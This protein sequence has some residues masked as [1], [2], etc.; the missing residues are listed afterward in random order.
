[1]NRL[2]STGT[3][4]RAQMSDASRAKVTVKAKGRK[5]WLTRPPTRPRGRKTA[6]VVRVELVM[7]LATSRVP[8]MHA[9]RIGSP[10]PRCR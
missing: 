9:W 6:T 5:N 7:A 1:M 8:S 10:L 3:T 4:V 2:A